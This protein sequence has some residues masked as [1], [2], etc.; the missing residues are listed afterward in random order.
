MPGAH[1]R[2]GPRRGQHGRR[3]RTGGRAPA[4]AHRW[5]PC[6][7]AAKR[8]CRR[9]LTSG[10]KRL[11]NSASRAAS[12][13]MPCSARSTATPPDHDPIAH[14][15]VAEAG[16]GGAQHALAQ[17]AGVGMH[18]GEGGIVADRADVAQVVGE[19]LQLGHQRAQPG[20]ARRRLDPQARPRR[21]G[22]RPGR[23][24]RCCRPRCGREL[25]RPVEIGA[26]HE[27][28]D[29]LVDIAQ[30]F[31]QPHHRLAAGGE[32]E[33]AGLDDAGMDRADRDLMQAL[34]FRRQERIGRCGARRGP[35]AQRVAHAPAAMV[36]PGAR[37][38]RAGRLQAEQVA[39]RALEPDRRRMLGADRGERRIAV[40]ARD[41]DLAGRFV[42]QRHV[43]RARLAPQSQ[44]GPVA[45]G[46]MQR[47]R[48]SR[49][50]QSTT[51][52]GHGR[53]WRTRRLCGRS[54]ARH[55][56]SS[57]QARD[58]LEPRHQRRRQED[59]GD[60][61]QSPD[62]RRAAHTTP[63][64]APCRRAARRRPPGSGAAA[65]RRTRSGGRAPG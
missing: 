5:P 52:R 29:P 43:D 21:R 56:A 62:G 33:M 53:C 55:S 12:T 28:L 22:R 23:R 61:D 45:R 63:R 18:Q 48:C 7:A 20:R 57:Q 39:D 19:T 15:A 14:Q 2:R 24:R 58:V 59:T 46:E 1:R 50:R 30:A 6:A 8:C 37:V 4:A 3:H 54:S 32:A 31:L 27:P 40:Q 17:D 36:E 25:R 47:S 51:A 34:A 49:P 42:E 38:R 64:P 13:A 65:A 16:V 10:A 35:L 11:R 9:V 41:P 44:Q 60:R 26:G